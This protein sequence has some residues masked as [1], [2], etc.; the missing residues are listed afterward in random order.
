MRHFSLISFLMAVLVSTPSHGVG[1]KGI[2][3]A[4][5]PEPDACIARYMLMRNS[6][7]KDS[8]PELALADHIRTV[9]EGLAKTDEDI[10][11]LAASAQNLARQVHAE[12]TAGRKS[13]DDVIFE[14]VLCDKAFGLE[15]VFE[16]R[17]P[18]E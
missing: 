4:F 18:S 7:P 16:T 17:E 12:V 13:V 5:Q 10:A 1:L 3:L 11:K 14:T 6:V 2:K 15:P 9:S 8:P